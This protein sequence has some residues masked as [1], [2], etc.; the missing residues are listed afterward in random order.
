M[1]G[2]IPC[3]EILYCLKKSNRP[4][5][6]HSPPFS[7]G[8]GANSTSSSGFRWG[9]LSIICVAFQL[10]YLIHAL[11]RKQIIMSQEY[12]SIKMVF[13]ISRAH[14]TC[15]HELTLFFLYLSFNLFSAETI[16]N[17]IC[18]FSLTHIFFFY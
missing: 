7:S 12:R 11:L 3:T 2:I 18:S 13:E 4:E 14:S 5:Q 16:K 1:G 10:F 17:S 6:K 15:S 8:S 9:L